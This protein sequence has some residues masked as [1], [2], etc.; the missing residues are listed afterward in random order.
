MACQTEPAQPRP[1]ATEKKYVKPARKAKYYWE[2]SSGIRQIRRKVSKRNASI[3]IDLEELDFDDDEDI[4]NAE[5]Q[6]RP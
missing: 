1:R 3:G 2:M 5:D 6:I 4:E